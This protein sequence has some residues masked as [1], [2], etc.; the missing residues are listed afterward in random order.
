MTSQCT[1][2]AKYGFK[3]TSRL[4]VSR[5]LEEVGSKNIL[6]EDCKEEGKSLKMADHTK[7]PPAVF[8]TCD[9]FT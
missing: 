8:H 9:L 4:L 2:V 7:Y 3:T 6:Q 5:C 1:K